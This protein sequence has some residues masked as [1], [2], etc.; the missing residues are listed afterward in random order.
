MSELHKQPFTEKTERCQ[1][2]KLTRGA[3]CL[4]SFG[5]HSPHR[6]SA[7]VQLKL[8]PPLSVVNLIM[9]IQQTADYAMFKVAA[10]TP[11]DSEE[12]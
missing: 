5:L 6:A 1:T 8:G 7:I 12:I 10:K 3:R 11:S 2:V 4:Q 9:H